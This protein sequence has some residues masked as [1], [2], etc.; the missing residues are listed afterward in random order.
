MPVRPDFDC[1]WHGQ[2]EREGP[3]ED[4]EVYKQWISISS[5]TTLEDVLCNPLVPQ[6]RT[7][8]GQ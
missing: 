6:G 1:L 8:G 7:G 4:C 5:Q 3:C 2:C